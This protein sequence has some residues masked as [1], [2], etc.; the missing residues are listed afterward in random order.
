MTEKMHQRSVETAA[1]RSGCGASAHDHT[2]Q[3]FWHVGIIVQDLD[4]AMAELSRGLGLR[5]S[6]VL[7]NP[8]DGWHFRVAFSFEGPPYIELL[9]GRPQPGSPWDTTHGN[10]VDY[11]GYWTTDIN[12][13]KSR[14]VDNGM[15]LDAEGEDD[16]G[17][18]SYHR[19]S[20]H[21]V[22]HT[23]IRLELVD[24]A[25]R[26]YFTQ[27]FFTASVGEKIRGFRLIRGVGDVVSSDEL[28]GSKPTVVHFFPF[29]FSGTP[30][31]GCE[32]QLCK[33]ESH[34]ADLDS[35]GV[36]LVGVSHDSPFALAQWSR[37]LG[38]NYSLLSDWNWEAAKAFGVYLGEDM[39]TFTPAIGRGAFLVD[40][41]SVVRY[42][43]ICD[44]SAPLPPVDEV[45]DAARDLSNAGLTE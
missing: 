34:R 41:G 5:W 40:T 8:R 28:F 21:R 30:E 3:P 27:S 33:F 24:A 29:A 14:L 38:L 11:L 43:F 18:G 45:L 26:R 15:P 35:M 19:W 13:G 42:R 16:D 17:A 12:E 6:E 7:D 1:A 32:A 25:S 23:G 2:A 39:G 22:P 10:R 37:Q 44:E 20:Y 4:A 36:N 9:E 31:S